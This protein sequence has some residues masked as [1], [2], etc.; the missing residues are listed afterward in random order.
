LRLT[1]QLWLVIV[2]WL[3]VGC[4]GETAV[5]ADPP[6]DPTL[7]NPTQ[8]L[9]TPT[10]AA[11]VPTPPLPT[12]AVTPQSAAPTPA[13][14]EARALDGALALAPTPVVSE[15]LALGRTALAEGDYAAA[16]ETF[17][18]ALAQPDGLDEAGQQAALLEL[19]VA[20]LRD[21]R[22]PDAIT[23]FN[24]LLGLAG[25]QAPPAARFHLGQAHA[26]LGDHRAALDAYAAYLD[27]N[28]DMAAYVQPLLAQAHLALGD[29]A[30]A[31][32]AYEAALQGPAQRLHAVG[33]RQTLARFYL[34]DGNT[35]AAIAQYDA[36]HEVAF[37][38]TTRGQM[39]YLAGAAA[40]QAG[41][42]EAGYARY[43]FGVENYPTVYETYLGLVALVQAGVAVDEFQ[44]GLVNYHAGSYQPALA[45]FQ[46]YIAANPADYRADAHLYLAWT[47][48][49]LGDLETALA[50]LDAYAAA[51]PAAALLERARLLARAGQGAQ[52]VAAY[53]AFLEAF[54]DHPEA[55]AANWSAATLTARA[56]DRATAVTLYTRLADSYP[57]AEQAPEALFRAGWLLRDS[58]VETAVQ[59]WARGATA[60]PA[61]EYGAAAL[62]WLLRT[63]QT[64]AELAATARDLAAGSAATHYYAL[65]AQDLAADAA[66]FAPSLPFALPE[67]ET[68]VQAEAEAWLRA[69]LELD[70]AD[71]VRTPIPDLAADPRL[72]V[73]SKL[74]E[75][76]LWEEAKRELE[77]LREA[78][79]DNALA[80]YQLALLYRDLGLYRSS[81]LAAERVMRL[82]ETNAFTAP[83]FLGRLAYPVYYAD[84]ILP[85]AAQYGYDPRLQFA[86]VR[87]ESLFESFARSGAAAQGL[88]QV[89]P[90]TGVFIA[91]RLGWPNYVNEDLYKPYVG[92]A[93]G[94]YYLDLQL[95]TFG[96][97][98]HA[99]LAAYNAGPGN[100]AKWY[101]TAGGDHDLFVE[102]VN[103][104]ETR[105]YIERIYLGFVA[106]RM[107]YAP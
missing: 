71:D 33:L 16:V 91:Q 50:E 80:S 93:F 106:Y 68:A 65:R 94:A 42:S 48:T 15:R 82:T 11:G 62:V 34:E 13:A 78:Y 103:F 28:P 14:P 84:L 27:A 20:Y 63:S 60:Y 46:R 69:R 51:E 102:T 26:A 18:A 47:H 98:V 30:A 101:E 3:L 76:G 92:L 25:D 87:Q 31:L 40:I 21:G 1:K 39:T 57:A 38:P 100:A 22:Y 90:D 105:L 12:P 59:L 35:D 58:D 24:Q 2:L 6:A 77:S 37:T 8:L 5:P 43:L 29:R 64:P 41:D 85:L 79:Q 32:A 19:G 81:I 72:A 83:R 74:W 104:P 55:A 10:L 95:N 56:G 96:G 17:S 89:I 99:A 107:L 7:S 88:S 23:I 9:P 45:A 52:A 49:A 97:H 53:L 66:P 67:E 75:L 54:P 4:G 61:A 70:A 36:I 73:G 44:R 86:L